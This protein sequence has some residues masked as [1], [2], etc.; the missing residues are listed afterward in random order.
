[1]KPKLGK[2]FVGWP[3]LSQISANAG[4][5]VIDTFYKHARI[6]A[7]IMPE[8][9][10][11][12]NNDASSHKGKRPPL[13]KKKSRPKVVA[14]ANTVFDLVINSFAACARCSYFFTGYR[15]LH[16]EEQIRQQIAQSG[17]IWLSLTGSY[18]VLNLIHTSFGRE[19]TADLV[20]YQLCCPDCLRLYS[21][22][23][24]EPDRSVLLVQLDP[25]K[26]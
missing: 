18:P 21:Y 16:E 13:K 2:A 9:Q 1:M 25:Q 11:L 22:E 24:Q 4:F 6:N 26:R 7:Q 19:I 8:E 10:S 17:D 3:W 12:P 5:S 23:A 15:V 14:A 20:K